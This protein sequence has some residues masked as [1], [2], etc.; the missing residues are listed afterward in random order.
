MMN[1]S[2]LFTFPTST[3][4][5]ILLALIGNQIVTTTTAFSTTAASHHRTTTHKRL[6]PFMNINLKTKE[7]QFDIKAVFFSSSLS[8]SNN[9]NNEN[10]NNDTKKNEPGDSVRLA[11]KIRPSLNP[12]IINTLSN[13][14]LERSSTKTSF[15]LSPNIQPI[16]IM[17]EA[18]TLATK[19]IQDRAKSSEKVSGDDGAFNTQESQLVAGRIIGV[20]MRLGELEDELIKRVKGTV[21]VKKYGEES[22]FGVCKSELDDDYIPSNIRRIDDNEKS[23]DIR[24]IEMLSKIKD[25]PLMRMCRAE[26]VYAIFLKNIEMPAMDKIGEIPVDSTSVGG[27]GGGLDFID[28]DRLEVLFPEGFE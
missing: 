5:I 21:W 11:N 22:M 25:D 13:A 1:Q 20:I 24:S 15:I 17:L 7:R 27:A 18:S 6:F 3:M 23:E 12:T 16:E 19:A 10:A 28:Q 8:S 4:L 9:D 14:L 2:K 26:C